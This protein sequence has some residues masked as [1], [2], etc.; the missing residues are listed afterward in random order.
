MIIFIVAICLT[1]CTTSTL[2]DTK[3]VDTK[4]VDELIIEGQT[5]ETELMNIL[6]QPSFYGIPDLPKTG[7]IWVYVSWITKSDSQIKTVR[8]ALVQDGVVVEYS[9]TNTVE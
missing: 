8:E 1:A 9:Y 2:I 4:S 3:P 7:K 6:G 5:T